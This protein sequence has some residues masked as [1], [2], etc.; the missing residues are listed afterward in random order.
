RG[1][2]PRCAP[3]SA[4]TAHPAGCADVR[5]K[6]SPPRAPAEAPENSY[7]ILPGLQGRTQARPV[8]KCARI[9]LASRRD[10]AVPTDTLGTKAGIGAQQHPDQGD[11]R[12]ILGFAERQ[13]IGALQL[14]AD[15]K[16]VAVLPL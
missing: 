9:G 16:V 13:L 1:P 10:V 15:G 7:A 11:Q 4:A 12:V 8:K 6:A 2:R 3:A 5:Q 14:D